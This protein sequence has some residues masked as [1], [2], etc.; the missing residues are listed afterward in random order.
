M[1]HSG[2]PDSDVAAITG[3]F[4]SV[5]VPYQFKPL[6]TEVERHGAWEWSA[7]RSEGENLVSYLVVFAWQARQTSARPG[8][9][10]L[11]VWVGWD[12]GT[13]FSRDRAARGSAR[14]WGSAAEYVASTLATVAAARP[15]RSL[16][17]RYIWAD[18]RRR[19]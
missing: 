17:E 3:V 19:T 7:L 14:D 4:E 1:A 10:N 5:L 13:A 18:S 6:F 8:S 16:R 15:Q 12:D 11:E 9:I 2:R